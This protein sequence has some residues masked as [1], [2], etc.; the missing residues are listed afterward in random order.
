[1]RDAVKA[2]GMNEMAIQATAA[3]AVEVVLQAIQMQREVCGKST[4]TFLYGGNA[5]PLINMK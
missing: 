4:C 3:E 1:M 2:P 5:V